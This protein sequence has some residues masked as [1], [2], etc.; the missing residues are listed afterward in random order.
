MPSY[1]PIVLCF[2]KN[3]APYA[4]VTIYSVFINSNRNIKFY[5][6]VPESDANNIEPIEKL[7]SNFSVNIK[8]IPYGEV[9]FSKWKI[10]GQFSLSTY[11][12]LIIPSFVKEDK[13]VYL[14]SDTLVLKD[15]AELYETSLER[16][17]IAG[18]KD[19]YGEEFSLIPRQKNDTYINAGVLLM[20][21]KQL[22][23]E[24]F[25][26]KC[27]EIYEKYVEQ[28]KMFDQCIINK[29]AE[30]N[31]LVLDPKWN[32]QIAGIY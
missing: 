18:I 28:L 17:S 13:V 5:C 12:K 3:Y 31:K 16:F 29:Y 24:N 6:L 7:R 9:A 11:A 10:S 4:A 27:S 30:G 8:I 20:N 2:D 21:L 25:L 15:I 22:R 19:E 32:V 26:E 23:K 1:I 14:D